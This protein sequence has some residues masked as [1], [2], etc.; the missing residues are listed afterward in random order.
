M[1]LIIASAGWGSRM[2]VVK[3]WRQAVGDA[4]NAR[5]VSSSVA[6]G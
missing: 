6:G 4:G 2:R 3:G 1:K 5:N